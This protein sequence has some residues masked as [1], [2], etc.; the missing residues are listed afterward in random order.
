M[1]SDNSTRIETLPATT[2]RH[3]MQKSAALQK[4]L[5]SLAMDSSNADTESVEGLRRALEIM[6]GLSLKLRQRLKILELFLLQATRLQSSL[7]QELQ[8]TAL[9]V[10]ITMRL[11]TDLLVDVLG[12]LAQAFL[13]VVAATRESALPEGKHN[14][15]HAIWQALQCWHRQLQISTLIGAPAPSG[16]WQLALGTLRQA[17]NTEDKIRWGDEFRRMLAL[18]VAQPESF[19]PRELAFLIDYLQSIG[20]SITWLAQRETPPPNAYWLDPVRHLPP[21]ALARRR[22]PPLEPDIFFFDCTALARQARQHL[23]Q[24]AEGT[25]PATLGLPP[26][27]AAEDYRHALAHAASR[28]SGS[29]KRQHGRRAGNYRVEVCTHSGTLWRLLSGD[30]GLVAS[31]A[32]LHAASN[33]LVTN[34]SPEGYAMLHVAG[35]CT[36]LRAGAA[37]GLRHVD[38]D[39]W[40]VCLVRWARSENPEHVELGL[41]L[42]APAARAVRLAYRGT[43]APVPAL[44]LPALPALQRGEALLT[45]RGHF[46]PGAFT[47]L[48]DDATGVRL[49][50]CETGTLATCT[51]SIEIFEFSRQSLLDLI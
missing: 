27:A 46:N 40:R 5:A 37:L 31:T 43:A 2:P 38:S 20:P 24:L 3:A 15:A 25:P 48:T 6:G 36:G 19:T 39:A 18:T 41:E 32:P 42:M 8:A 7:A 10:P 4:V 47:L 14:P 45:A 44:L 1:L 21:C 30:I 35:P 26:A 33:W 49:F 16:L 23:G 22:P 34:E 50:D 12:L 17:A 9:P 51:A 11:R 29:G 28:W 13:A